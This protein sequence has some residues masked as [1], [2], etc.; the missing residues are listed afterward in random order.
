MTVAAER[1]SGDVGHLEWSEEF[2][3]DIISIDKDH[4]DL[5][6]L[7]NVLVDTCES[8]GRFEEIVEAYQA[9]AAHTQAHFQREEQLMQNIDL[10][11]LEAHITQHRRLLKEAGEVANDL[12]PDSTASD[13][14]AVLAYLRLW[15]V[16]HI[17]LSDKEIL[18]H[19]HR[20]R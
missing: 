16:R 20:Q 18:Q 3:V 7:F 6:R 9:L 11:G 4:Q 17:M 14:K 13:L 8:G 5:F 15:V 19:L 1:G 12:S 10:P 2:S